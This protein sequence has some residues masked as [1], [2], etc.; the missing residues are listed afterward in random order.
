MRRGGGYRALFG[1]GEGVG[2]GGGTEFVGEGDDV[3]GEG[4][5]KMASTEFV[6]EGGDVTGEGGFENFQNGA[7]RAARVRGRGG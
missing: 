6:D 4:D 5:S 7:A 2:R 1:E 3:T